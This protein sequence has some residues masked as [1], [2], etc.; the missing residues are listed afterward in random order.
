[1][2]EAKKRG[3]FDERKAEAIKKKNEQKPIAKAKRRTVRSLS[4]TVA[5][6]LG[7][8]RWNAFNTK[9]NR[10]YTNRAGFGYAAIL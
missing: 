8:F 7:M 4:L 6:I 1:M 3:N 2:G 9:S 5:A 10:I